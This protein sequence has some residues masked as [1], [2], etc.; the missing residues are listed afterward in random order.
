[1]LHHH[2]PDSTTD[3]TKKIEKELISAFSSSNAK[4]G[5]HVKYLTL[6]EVNPVCTIAELILEHTTNL[7]YLNLLFHL[8]CEAAE[9]EDIIDTHALEKALGH[10]SSSL[11]WLSIDYAAHTDFKPPQLPPRITLGAVDLRHMT[12]LK[13][14]RVPIAA[15]LGWRIE[16]S[17]KLR[18]V[19]PT[20]LVHPVISRALTMTWHPRLGYQWTPEQ[21]LKT[22]LEFV[23]QEKWSELTPKLQTIVIND[24][25]WHG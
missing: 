2:S 17:A 14:L 18:Q 3:P 4:P 24:S 20:S 6:R 23:D 13:V 7:T 8:A 16:N 25:A 12:A 1:V 22:L 21:I 19:L 11:E 10:V 5:R 15:L 9:F